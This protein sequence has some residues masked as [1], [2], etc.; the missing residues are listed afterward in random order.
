MILEFNFWNGW[1]YFL[2]VLLP[3]GM[4][5]LDSWERNNKEEKRE[6]KYHNLTKHEREELVH[7]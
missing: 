1:F 4:F 3:F 6:N 7:G 2:F 5:V